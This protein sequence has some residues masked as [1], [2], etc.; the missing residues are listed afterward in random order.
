[1]SRIGLETPFLG[2]LQDVVI[3][4]LGEIYPD[5]TLHREDVRLLLEAEEERFSRT[6]EV[7]SRLLDDVIARTR[8]N[9]AN[10]IPA[11]AAFK[12]HDTYG[13]PIEVTAEIAQ[14]AGLTV[15]EAGFAELMDEQRTRARAA[16]KG[17]DG[18]AE[19]LAAFVR[20]AGFRTDFKGY[21]TLDLETS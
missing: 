4:T 2:R 13:F 6:L 3:E 16:A 14:E 7:G 12:L 11:E 5:L 17:G 18:D 9:R 10:A 19:R 15:N 21:Q 20:S 1:G 8:A